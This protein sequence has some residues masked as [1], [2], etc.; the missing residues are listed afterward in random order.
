MFNVSECEALL[1]SKTGKKLFAQFWRTLVRQ[2]SS[3][4]ADMHT[5]G[6]PEPFMDLA[7]F[8]DQRGANAFNGV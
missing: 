7:A 5:L 8:L 6:F 1:C 2:A 4:G 3:F